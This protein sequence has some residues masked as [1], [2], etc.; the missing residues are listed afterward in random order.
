MVTVGA[1]S[2]GSMDM[3]LSSL[4]SLESSVGFCCCVGII[5]PLIIDWSALIAYSS[6]LGLIILLLGAFVKYLVA[7]MMRYVG[8]TVSVAM[9]WC[10]NFNV[11]VVRF[12][13]VAFVTKRMRRWCFKYGAMY[14]PVMVCAP[15]VCRRIVLMCANVLV[16]GGA[17]GVASN[18]YMPSSASNAE[19][20]GFFRQMRIMLSV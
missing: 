20:P 13:H 12:A 4:L 15:H 9:L 17:I 2:R 3:L 7:F 11:S 16:P 18:K 14:H 10:L 6:F 5:L 19:S 8:V 1:I